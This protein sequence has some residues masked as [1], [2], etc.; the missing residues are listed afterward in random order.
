YSRAVDLNV[1]ITREK[2]LT[3]IRAAGRDENIIITPHR[4]MGLEEGIE[5]IADDELV[6]VTPQSIR[7]RKKILKQADRPRRRQEDE[8]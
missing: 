5:W 8:E 6:E 1:N 3:N 4:E 2:K 7:L